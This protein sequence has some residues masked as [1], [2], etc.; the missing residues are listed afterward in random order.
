V[1]DKSAVGTVNWPLRTTR[2]RLLAYKKFIHPEAG[3]R[4]VKE[5]WPEQH[6]WLWEKLEAFK[7]VFAPRVKKLNASNYVADEQAVVHNL[8]DANP[9]S[10]QSG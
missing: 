7:K 3:Y 6:M 10:S 8:V 5:Q 9:T 1:A 2:T 4:L